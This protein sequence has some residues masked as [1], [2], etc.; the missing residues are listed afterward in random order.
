MALWQRENPPD[1]IR[2]IFLGAALGLGA[3][4]FVWLLITFLSFRR[5]ESDFL[6]WVQ[7][8]RTDPLT[9]AAVWITNIGSI[10]LLVP[11]DAL[12]CA[13]LLIR[14]RWRMAL[15]FLATLA[16][17][18]LLI[19]VRLLADRPAPP[20]EVRSSTNGVVYLAEA[21]LERA[22]QTAAQA[23]APPKGGGAAPAAA[24]WYSAAI[25]ILYRSLTRSFPSNHAAASAYFYGLL[26]LLAWRRGWHTVAGGLAVLIGLIGASRVYMGVHYPSDVVASWSLAWAG[27]QSAI[28]VLRVPAANDISASRQM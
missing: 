17:Y 7:G 18:P 22:G 1:S 26:L 14:K 24:P 20:A 9:L 10:N 28:H 25:N 13:G 3:F 4:L 2:W 11:L 12:V 16:W 23:K 19:P 8:I 21:P 27:L 15:L 5:L 6:E